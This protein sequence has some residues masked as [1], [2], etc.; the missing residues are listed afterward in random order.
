MMQCEFEKLIGTEINSDDY[1]IVEYVYMFHPSI[2]P[3]HG[4]KQIAELYKIGGMA[5]IGDMVRTAKC[6][7][8]L[9]GRMVTLRAQ[10]RDLQQ[11]LDTLRVQMD[12]LKDGS[13]ATREL[14][15]EA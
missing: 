8:R 10:M 6:A 2:D 9:E 14:E 12:E 3:V 4:K 5:V 1:R 11:E 7:E 15:K 13:Y